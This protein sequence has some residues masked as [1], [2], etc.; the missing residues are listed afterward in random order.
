MLPLKHAAL[1]PYY[2]TASTQPTRHKYI[3]AFS[4]YVLPSSLKLNSLKSKEGRMS[5]MHRTGDL[6]AY[7]LY[8]ARFL[9]APLIWKGPL[10]QHN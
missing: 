7:G 2:D 8:T 9:W 1:H 10:T 3:P 4:L 5:A 6:G